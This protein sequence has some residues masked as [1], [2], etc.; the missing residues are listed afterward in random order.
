MQQSLEDDERPFGQ[1]PWRPYAVPSQ[2]STSERFRQQREAS[3]KMNK[4]A[5]LREEIHEKERE[6]R[7]YLST[8]RLASTSNWVV[9]EGIVIP[10]HLPT[11]D[12][13]EERPRKRKVVEVS[14]TITTATRDTAAVPAIQRRINRR[15]TS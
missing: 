6:R 7:R 1:R 15:V 8:P 13:E 9:E 4:T 3:V 12:R 2:T 11:V 5:R 10:K 14:A